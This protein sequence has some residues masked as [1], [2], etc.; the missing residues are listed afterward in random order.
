ML[1]F[2][3]FDEFG[4]SV[5]SQSWRGE[6]VRSVTSSDLRGSAESAQEECMKKRS[7]VGH[8]TFL[9][10]SKRRAQSIYLL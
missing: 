8:T 6:L 2:V 10:C 4:G 1:V 3:Q 5:K 7:K 9:P